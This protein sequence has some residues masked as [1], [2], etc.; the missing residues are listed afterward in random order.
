[1]TRKK[2][3]ESFKQEVKDKYGNEFTI[4]GDYI[5]TDTKIRFRHNSEKCNNSEFLMT[6]YNFM[7]SKTKPCRKC[8]KSTKNS[9]VRKTTMKE[10]KD[11]VKKL[12]GDEYTVLSKDLINM[13]TNILMRHNS[14]KCN[15]YEYLVMPKDFKSGNRCPK[16]SGKIRYTTETFAKHIDEITNGEFSLV[17][18]Y[19][20]T[21][22]KIK[23][24]HNSERCNNNVFEI[25]PTNFIQRKK[26]PICSTNS[27]SFTVGERKDQVR[28]LV[29]NEYTILLDNDKKYITNSEK[30]KVRHNSDIC[31]NYIFETNFNDFINM[32]RRCPKCKGI[33]MGKRNTKT[34]D[35][36]LKEVKDKYGDH[37]KVLD[38]YVKGNEKLRILHKDCGRIS[39]ITPD[40]FLMGQTCHHC[41][42]A[43]SKD[44]KE[45][46][47]FVESILDN[48]TKVLFNDRS[49]LPN[50]K[51]LDIYLPKEK[52]A[53]EYNGYYWHSDSVKPDKNYHLKKQQEANSLGITLYFIDEV[54]WIDPVK[55]LIL[56]SRIRYIL[57]KMNKS[58]YARKTEYYIPTPSEERKFLNENHIQGYA[59]SSIK[60]ALKYNN[61]IVGLLTFIKGRANVN[62]SKNSSN[63]IELLRYA[64]K[65]D[66]HIPGG[67][68]KLIKQSI[69]MIKDKYPDV[70]RISTFADASLSSGKLYTTNG[71]ILDHRS[72]PSYFYVRNGVRINRYTYQKKKLKKLFPDQYDDKLTEFKIIDSVGNIYRVWNTGNNVYY[73]DI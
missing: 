29:G 67:F 26:C 21:K 55:K 1:M 53:F 42:V 2:T 13:K 22:T 10:F 60:L 32:S 33:N 11:Q 49:T 59:P 3:T 4:L 7:R 30:F 65:R 36:F 14:K 50:K 73:R 18:E 69:K 17:S 56:K 66:I 34:N 43:V 39:I 57:N 48:N 23:V 61:G 58:I 8:Y 19:V 63:T 35:Q 25:R 5:N 38:E 31:G 72:K 68:S 37:Y 24:R 44:E 12:V 70:T 28:K 15:N 16:C 64:S 9:G 52:I 40:H 6:P 46:D 54:D 20:N 71:F 45:L 47:N 51:E 27:L 62:A 41:G